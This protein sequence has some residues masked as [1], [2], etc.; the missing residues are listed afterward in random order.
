[1][2][3]VLSLGGE[4]RFEETGKT[5]IALCLLDQIET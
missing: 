4:A 3:M 5:F 2:Y 1:M